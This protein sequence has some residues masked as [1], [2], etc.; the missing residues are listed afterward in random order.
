M[1]ELLALL[2][3]GSTAARFVLARITHG[4]G[5][6]VLQKE[7][8]QTRLADGRAGE[9]PPDAVALTLASVTGFL[10]RPGTNGAPL[11]LLAVAT[12]AVR[13]APNRECLLQVLKERDG[14]DVRLLSDREEAH[15]GALSAMRHLPIQEGVIGDLGGGS[16]QLTQVRRGRIT[17]AGGVPVGAVRMTRRFLRGDPPTP[18]EIRTLRD[19]VRDHLLGVLPAA[20]RGD[21]LLG[22]GGT[23]RTLARMHLAAEGGPRRKRHALCL[24]LA[25]VT[26]LRERIEALPLRKRRRIPGLKAERADI[27]LAGAITVEEVMRFGGYGALTVCKGGVRDG[28]LWQET[29]NSGLAD[30]RQRVHQP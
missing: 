19:V 6:R 8:I 21:E 25:D 15:L 12:A 11:R 28:I 18:G 24:T 2:D 30:D 29:F 16:L 26:A 7:R 22:L 10:E 23:V 5:Y 9:L 17:S 13:D 27:I 3:L 14:A 20:R 1:P 4:A